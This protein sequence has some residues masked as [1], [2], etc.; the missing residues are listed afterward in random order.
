VVVAEPAVVSWVAMR[1]TIVVA[2]LLVLFGAAVA[3]KGKAA[4]DKRKADKAKAKD[5]DKV[6]KGFWKILVKPKAVWTLYETIAPDAKGVITVETY[7]V[8]KI[9]KADVARLRWTLKN[10]STKE[11]I[12]GHD[13]RYTQ[14]GVTDAG[15]YI[16]EASMDDK[17][18]EKQLAGKPSRSDPPKPYEGTKQNQGRYLMIMNGLVCLGQGPLPGADDCPDTCDGTMCISPTDGVVTLYGNWAPGVSIF[19]QKG[20]E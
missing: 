18:V 7:D 9:G 6:D 16:M 19:A 8:R 11:D 17:A 1:T 5:D 15:L 4:S 3:D 14:V 10:G 2:V 20:Y 13:G 12:G